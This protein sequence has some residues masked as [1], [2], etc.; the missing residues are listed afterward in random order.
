MRWSRMTEADAAVTASEQTEVKA[1]RD[2][3]WG[4]A[5]WTAGTW[6]RA[7]RG[8]TGAGWR[9]ARGGWDGH[10]LSLTTPFRRERQRTVNVDVF[11]ILYP[12][13]LRMSTVCA[14]SREG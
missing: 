2:S 12:T 7:H 3:P 6:M 4:E 8:W 5:T 10:R 14:V 11:R 9:D 13:A 1:S